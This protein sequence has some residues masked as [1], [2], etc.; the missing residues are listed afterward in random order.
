VRVAVADYVELLRDPYIRGCAV[1][2]GF[3]TG[4][5]IAYMA[6]SSFVFQSFYGLSR[7][8]F[9]LAF[10][11]CA[12]G[13]VIGSQAGRFVAPRAGARRLALT[14]IATLIGAGGAL[15]AVVATRAPLPVALVFMFL[16]VVSVGLSQPS[17]TALALAP[18]PEK[19]A[20]VAALVGL[21]Q[22]GFGV[23]TAP[24]AGLGGRHLA[25]TM[26]IV[27]TGCGLL[28]LVAFLRIRL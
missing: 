28:A 20:R 19:A 13:V 6:S 5:V 21:S 27:V 22:F 8:E 18:H 1:T 10:G 4:G 7:Q 16:I 17:L 12:T 3:A 26:T 11:V 25:L 14:G 23:V 2:V 9:A 24:A 15:I